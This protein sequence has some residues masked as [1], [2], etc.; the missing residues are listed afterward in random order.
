[1]YNLPHFKE[2]DPEI[3]KQFMRQYPFAML[4]GCNNNLPVATQVPLLI[5]ERDGKTFFKGH[6]MRNT[7]HHKAFTQN[8]QVLCVFAGSHS[9][10]SASWYANP[11]VA[12][13]WNYLSVHAKGVLRFLEEA[14]LLQI[15][16]ETTTHFEDNVHSPASFNNLPQAYVQQSA[17]AIIGFE[18]E[19]IHVDHVFKLSQNRDQESY[20]NIIDHLQQGDAAA[21]QIAT[22]MQHRE[23]RLFQ[24]D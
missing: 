10:V 19:V 5:E 4:I 6:I 21:Q 23:S 11:Q 24:A 2:P 14:Q 22:E 15:L 12:S 9:Y 18:I 1:M 7:D 3:I 8:N 20:R 16:E 13:T 17:K